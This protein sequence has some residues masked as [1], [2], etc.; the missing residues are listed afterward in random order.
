MKNIFPKKYQFSHDYIF[1]LHDLL[2]R[3]IAEGEE[4][5]IFTVD[6]KFKTKKEANTFH[7]L[8][9]SSEEYW[10]WLETH[11]YGWINKELARKQVFVSVLSDLCH[12]LYE[13]IKCAKKGKLSVAFALLRKPLKENTLILEWLLYNPG[14]FGDKFH[15]YK[16]EELS[17]SKISKK[18]KIEILEGAI[19][20]CKNPKW[21]DPNFIYEL[22]YD[23]KSFISY[24]SAWNK[25]TH[26]ITTFKSFKTEPENINFVFSYTPETMEELWRHYYRSLPIL[27]NH[28]V[29][30]AFAF[31]RNIYELSVITDNVLEIRRFIGFTLWA[32]EFFQES[33]NSFLL[34]Y[35]RD[36][37]KAFD[38][39]CSL[40]K[41]KIS[42]NKKNLYQ[43]YYSSGLVCKHCKTYIELNF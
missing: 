42:L 29:E 14:E 10:E 3:V 22:R 25:A 26:L 23:K 28:L 18:Q 34:D 39:K 41:E 11:G 30:V 2:A 33:D 32:K 38:L 31:V 16:L 43:F 36:V 4:N 35:A 19:S 21:I 6:I 37:L 20:K 15:N 12:F 24:E 9:L 7:E 13:S 40:C 1:F 17:T 8:N 27:L 5:D